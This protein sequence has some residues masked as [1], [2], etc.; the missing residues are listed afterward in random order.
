MS[1]PVINSDFSN[2]DGSRCY[3]D[4]EASAT[5]R[6]VV[7]ELPLN[8]VH[9]LGSG[10]RHY[11][12]LFMT[13]RIGE[14]FSL[15]LLDNHPDDQK[16][17]FG[18]EVL[19]CGSWIRDVRKLPNC[20]G[21]LWYDGLGKPHLQGEISRRI[22]LSI[23]LDIL[24]SRYYRTDWNQGE[25]SADELFSLVRSIIEKYELIGVDICGAPDITQSLTSCEI[26]GNKNIIDRLIDLFRK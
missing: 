13:E 14:P 23:D 18:D 2:L 1:F 24:D 12:S 20:K 26:L 10:D 15:I 21:T 25:L 22:Y 5:M 7:S 4:S 16:G 3:C 8:A 17:A 11:V 9:L 19:S 6:K